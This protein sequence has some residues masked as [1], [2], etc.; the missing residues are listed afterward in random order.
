M[1]QINKS[2]RISLF[3]I[4]STDCDATKCP[5]AIDIP[6]T[7]LQVGERTGKQMVNCC[8][9]TQIFCDRSSCP[10][11]I[12]F[13]DDEGTIRPKIVEGRC[14]TI[15]ECGMLIWFDGAIIIYFNLFCLDNNVTQSTLCEVEINGTITR[16]QIGEKWFSM[17]NSTTCM[18]F[19]C[20]RSDSTEPFVNSIGILCNSQCP[21]V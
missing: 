2:M 14:C 6:D 8:E 10:A 18:N 21:E 16:K 3:L 5:P 19:E 20:L 9:V 4:D 7:L 1:I 12:Q 13:C 17:V 15:D 11:R